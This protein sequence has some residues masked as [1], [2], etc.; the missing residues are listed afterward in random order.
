MSVTTQIVNSAVNAIREERIPTRNKWL[1][2][3]AWRTI[4]YYYYDLD[5]QFGFTINRFIRAI[6]MFGTA[7]ESNVFLGNCTGVHLRTQYFVKY[8]KDGKKSTERVMFL[9]LAGSKTTEPKEPTDIPGWHQEREKSNAIINKTSPLFVGIRA[10][11]SFKDRAA[12]PASLNQTNINIS[13][14]RKNIP[15]A[16][17]S[18]SAS[19]APSSAITPSAAAVAPTTTATITPAPAIIS[20]SA[21]VAPSTPVTSRATEIPAPPLSSSYWDSPQARHLFQPRPEESVEACLQR[22]VDVLNSIFNDWSKLSE[23]IEGGEETVSEL[24]DHQKQ[25]LVHKCLY[26]RI[27]YE[28]ALFGMGSGVVSWT[29]CT[30]LTVKETKQFGLTTFCRPR[31]IAE[32]N[33]DFRTMEFFSVPYGVSNGF[34]GAELFQIFPEAQRMLLAWGKKNLERLNA[35]TAREYLLSEVIPACREICNEELQ[36]HG[37]PPFMPDEFMKFCRLKTLSVTTAWRW[38]R[39]LGFAY[40]KNEKCYYTDRHELAENVRYRLKFIRRYFEHELRC[41]CWVQLTEAQGAALEQLEKKPLKQGLGHSY[42]DA[43]GLQMR[44]FH[45]DCHDGLHEFINAET[46]VFG[47]N[48]SV[49]FPEGKRPLIIVG[50]D[51]MITYHFCSPQR[52]GRVQMGRHLS[53]QRGRVRGLWL[54][55]LC[56]ANLVSAPNLPM[57]N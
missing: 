18:P 7:V 20:P 22:R 35:E 40:S 10:L 52:A 1:T 33:Q 34:Q 55:V 9:L 29:K 3:E 53:C 25:R 31:S 19:V 23:V 13:E 57:T 14:L 21:A 56:C 39:Q 54:V 43:N 32:M 16:S 36:Q 11:P 5:D 51:E 47:G 48:R 30:E 46:A 27:A 41:F 49:R 42:A 44:E 24:S 26:L 17:I 38:L 2:V 45:V 15:S 50:Q 6:K 28:K 4:L 8:G 37:Y 12:V